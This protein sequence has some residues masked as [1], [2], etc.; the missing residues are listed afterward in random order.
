MASTSTTTKKTPKGKKEI[1]MP[2]S[3]ED[4]KVLKKGREEREYQKRILDANKARFA[5]AASAITT[6]GTKTRSAVT[7]GR[8]IK[9]NI[10]L[11]HTCEA[12]KL[13]L[14]QGDF[15]EVASDTSPG[16]NRPAGQG[17]IKS[18]EKDSTTNLPIA[19][20]RVDGYVHHDVPL[21]DI[22]VVDLNCILGN[23]RRQH[24]DIL[25]RI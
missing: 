1:D 11:V 9:P 8:D 16:R 2:I 18:V 24:A 13:M 14:R 19:S 6:S 5:A 12:G 23:T 10:E 21:K 3:K 15:V 20:V 25:N 17:F 4:A 22:T 7:T